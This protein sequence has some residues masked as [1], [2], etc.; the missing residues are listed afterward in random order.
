MKPTIYLILGVFF[1]A[2][3]L[4]AQLAITE[5]MTSESSTAAG[6]PGAPSHPDWWELSNFGTNDVDL[7]G[8]SWNDNAHG[9]L[10][11]ADAAPFN[12]AIIHAGEAVVFAQ[13]NSV[14]TDADAFRTW[15]GIS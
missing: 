1:A 12:G 13:Q 5:V 9:G 15:W 3:S 8:Y 6:V 14:I 11:S 7:A 4:H 2:A 10:F